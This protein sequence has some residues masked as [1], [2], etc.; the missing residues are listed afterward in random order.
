MNRN[1]IMICVVLLAAV[2]ATA[3]ELAREEGAWQALAPMP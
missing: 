2:I 1:L 3:G